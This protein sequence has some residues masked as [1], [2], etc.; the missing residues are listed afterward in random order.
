MENNNAQSSAG[1]QAPSLNDE[2][3]SALLKENY[4]EISEDKDLRQMKRGSP[5]F[6]AAVVE[7]FTKKNSAPT[8]AKGDQEEDATS[9]TNSEQSE[10]GSDDT[11]AG[12]GISDKAKKRITQLRARTTEAESELALLRKEVEELKKTKAT[13]AQEQKPAKAKDE[14]TF[15]APKPKLDDFNSMTDFQEALTD[16]K[17]EKKEHDKEQTKQSKE[18]DESARTGF[19]KFDAAGADIEKELGLESGDFKAVMTQEDL[20]FPQELWERLYGMEHGSRVAF[21]I[22]SDEDTKAKFLK[23]GPIDQMLMIGEFR[24]KISVQAKSRETKTVSGAKPP[25]RSLPKGK[26]N[27]SGISGTRAAPGDRPN[28]KEWERQRNAERL[29]K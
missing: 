1:N 6:A 14:S 25:S 13:P 11:E 9:K 20:R 21:E 3:V 15:E 17:I 22:F 12:H 4:K 16:W 7:K 27:G 24:G 10:S 28:Y 19:S 2:N 5:E 18:R 23:S 29:R 26:S 8:S